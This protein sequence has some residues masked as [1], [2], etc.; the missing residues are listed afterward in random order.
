MKEILKII[1]VQLQAGKATAA[2]PLGP[3]L[4]SC[5]IIPNTFVK[6]FNEKTSNLS[7]LL[8]VRIF[9]FTDKT[10]EFLVLTKPISRLI[11]DSLNLKSGSDSS[12]KIIYKMTT[13]EF[14]NIVQEKKKD[15]PF[16][17]DKGL[18]NMILGTAKNMGIT[19]LKS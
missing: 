16:L 6:D 8:S 3:I 11:L 15:F 12:K 7:G 14:L 19:L 18:K 2:P 10:F 13:E 5:Q 1:K 9:V 17:S 4:T